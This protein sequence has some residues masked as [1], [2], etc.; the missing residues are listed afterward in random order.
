MGRTLV[1]TAK[2]QEPVDVGFTDAEL[3]VR[4][5][6][7]RG[8]KAR[9]SLEEFYRLVI[10]H[11]ITKQPLEPA[12]HQCLMF[13]FLEAHNRCLFRQP[14]GTG[15][16]FGMAAVT[17]WLMG[18]DV[19]Q[20]GVIVSKTRGQASKVL[21]MVS[22][23]I[24]EP[25]LNRELALVY[26]WLVK[27]ERPNEQ[28]TQSALTIKR[29]PGIRD[30]SLLSVGLVGAIGGARLS[31]IVG[32][33]TV[34]LDNSATAEGRDKV[35]TGFEGRIL[36]RLD[37]VGSRAV[38]TNTPWDREDL[39]YYLEK[40]AGWPTLQMD[41][42]GYIKVV[43]AKAAWL[44]MAMKKFLRPSSRPG[45]YRLTAFGPD[46]DEEIPLWPE[47]I[48]AERIAEIRAETLPHEFARLYLCEPFDADAARCQLS[49]IE[50]CKLKGLGMPMV[51]EY[52]G[53]NPTYTG[54]DIG[55]GV[56]KRHDLSV[57]FTFELMPD[58]TRNILDIVSGRWSGPEIVRRL[59][60]IHNRY[61]SSVSVEN[62]QAQDFIRQFAI[63]AKKDIIVK[64]H[65]TGLNK[66]NTDFGV[67]SIFVELQQGAW[68]IP[69]D[70]DGRCM[71]EVQKWIDGMLQYQPP[72]AHTADHL[73]ASW[74]ARER[75]RKA[76]RQDPIPQRRAL[77]TWSHQQGF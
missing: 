67:E 70:T 13:S 21:A 23:Y 37:P 8:E 6:L 20:R 61:R 56:K 9:G 57:F 71:P 62:N 34:D 22:D 11:E 1:S 49:W 4:A 66:I 15:K 47:R 18:G 53:D 41:I 73:M 52:R 35:R 33:D 74:I 39:T 45:Y 44:A 58:G 51:H 26:P 2:K 59:I 10:K 76:G 42:Y 19:T 68:V 48:T 31:W 75:A 38:V 28:W 24:T 63:E 60:D 30:A 69:C 5:L 65:H 43:N 50:T 55:I 72:P 40:E 3:A 12:P 54:L 77:S 64:A 32:D 36:A 46:P 16:T 17:L 27:T 7:R 29:P 25:S 14:I